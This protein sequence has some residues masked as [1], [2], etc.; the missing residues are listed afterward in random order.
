MGDMPLTLFL[1]VAIIIVGL[2]LS[3]I[4][5]TGVRRRYNFFSSQTGDYT[6]REATG[7]QGT[8]KVMK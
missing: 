1:I 5:G 7:Y 4:A 2:Y 8:V 3:D 6:Q